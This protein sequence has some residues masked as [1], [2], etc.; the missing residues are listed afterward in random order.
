VNVNHRRSAAALLTATLFATGCSW[1]RKRD[2][3]SCASLAT[4]PDALFDS[5]SAASLVGRYQLVMISE[6][7]SEFSHSDRGPLELFA[8]DASRGGTAAAASGRRPDSPVLWGA[9][10]LTPHEITIPWVYDPSSRD[11]ARP[12]LL[13][14]AN[15]DVDLGGRRADGTPG[16]SMHIESV[17]RDG[18]GGTWTSVTDG[19]IPV[20]AHGNPLPVPHGRFC[21]LRRG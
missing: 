10:N 17:G 19:P 9:A 6:S 12:G 20:D 2:V 15:G 11:A 16:V 7:S 21:A 13:V 1:W 3:E 5:T 18:I 14:H 4:R 8:L